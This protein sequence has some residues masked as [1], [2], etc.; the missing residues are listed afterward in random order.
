M[1]WYSPK[2]MTE[3]YFPLN[4]LARVISCRSV[5]PFTEKAWWA[6]AGGWWLTWEKVTAETERL[7][8]QE[9]QIHEHKDGLDITEYR[10]REKNLFTQRAVAALFQPIK[11]K[12]FPQQRVEGF[13]CAMDGGGV[14]WDCEGSDITHLLHG[15]LAFSRLIQ[16]L[17][18]FQILGQ[19][20]QHRERL[21]EIDLKDKRGGQI[22]CGWSHN[23]RHAGSLRALV[24]LKAPF[25][26][27]SSLCS[28]DWGNSWAY[29]GYDSVAFWAALFP[30]AAETLDWMPV[31]VHRTGKIEINTI[32]NKQDTDQFSTHTVKN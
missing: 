13:S 30:G 31:T 21:V 27:S 3:I 22:T 6:A 14:G 11:L 2:G 10:N 1:Y 7:S 32:W 26:C 18:V 23:S 5:Q 4:L 24:S 19:T 12:C 9:H 29:R 28:I 20:L 16:Q 8:P 25:R 15:I 17:V